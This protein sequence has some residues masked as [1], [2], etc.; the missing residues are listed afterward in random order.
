MEKETTLNILWIDDSGSLERTESVEFDKTKRLCDWINLHCAPIH[1]PPHKVRAWLSILTDRPDYREHF[2]VSKSLDKQLTFEQLEILPFQTILFEKQSI[3]STVWFMDNLT[4]IKS[5]RVQ[6]HIPQPT[7]TPSHFQPISQAP[8][9]PL[10]FHNQQLPLPMM[11]MNQNRIPREIPHNERE[12]PV[13]FN[14]G[15]FPGLYRNKQQEEQQQLS[16]EEK[17][18]QDVIYESLKEYRK[19]D[20]KRKAT[21]KK[22]QE[23]QERVKEVQDFLSKSEVSTTNASKE[24]TF[25]ELLLEPEYDENELLEDFN[26]DEAYY[27]EGGDGYEEG[28][29]QV[30]GEGQGEERVETYKVEEP[31]HEEE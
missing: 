19:E 2:M 23:F 30:E 24:T 25:D 3:D 10:L 11:I 27:D 15:L 26:Y 29:E 28:E 8:N 31:Y 4:T 14:S 6:N 12:T 16:S 18:M 7:F 13:E 20:D 21:E 1:H 9:Q 17:I 5:S 22:N